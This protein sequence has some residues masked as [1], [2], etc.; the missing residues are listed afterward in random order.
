MIIHLRMDFLRYRYVW[1]RI[2][3][4]SSASN[5]FI[6]AYNH[7]GVQAKNLLQSREQDLLPRLRALALTESSHTIQGE[8]NFGLGNVDSKPMQEFLEQHTVNWLANSIPSPQ[9]VFVSE[10]NKMDIQLISK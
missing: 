7:G 4:R 3:S 9:R 6:L 2:V 8:L 10:E 1:D 5:I